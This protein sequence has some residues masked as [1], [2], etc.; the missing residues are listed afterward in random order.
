MR[1]RPL[2]EL[3]RWTRHCRIIATAPQSCS[4]YLLPLPRPASVKRPWEALCKSE[5]KANKGAKSGSLAS[6]LNMEKLEK[7]VLCLSSTH[8]GAGL[9]FNYDLSWLSSGM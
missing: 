9:C 3:A 7:Q 8:N 5:G 4:T 2:E 6:Q 1:S